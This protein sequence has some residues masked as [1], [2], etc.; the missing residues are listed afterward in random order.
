MKDLYLTPQEVN[1]LEKEFVEL[2][3]WVKEK[4]KSLSGYKSSFDDSARIVTEWERSY[5]RKKYAELKGEAK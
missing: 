4:I 1:L 3:E 5:W 2:E